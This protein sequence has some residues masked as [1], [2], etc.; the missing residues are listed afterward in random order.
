MKGEVRYSLHRLNGCESAE[1]QSLRLAKYKDKR[2]EYNIL[3]KRK[4]EYENK[5][6]LD[7][8][9][10]FRKKRFLEVFGNKE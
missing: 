3:I 7:I 4:K 9:D 5:K 2:R 10:D 6:K 1:D 8:A